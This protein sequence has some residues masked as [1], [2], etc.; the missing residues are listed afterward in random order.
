MLLDLG[1]WVWMVYTIHTTYTTLKLT[2]LLHNYY[3]MNSFYCKL[4][5]VLFIDTSVDFQ[6]RFLTVAKD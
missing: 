2:F 5:V 3:V 6:W 4:V 1:E